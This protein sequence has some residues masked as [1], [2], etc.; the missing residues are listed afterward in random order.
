VLLGVVELA[1]RPHLAG[2]DRVEVEQH[3]G[4]HE[5]AGQAAAAGLVGAGDEPDAERT[6]ESEQLAG[7]AR[8]LL[9]AGRGS[10]PVGGRAIRVLRG[11]RCGQAAST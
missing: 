6:I 9:A 1:E 4:G 3:G 11:I 8:T 2:S 7:G 10:G 5:R